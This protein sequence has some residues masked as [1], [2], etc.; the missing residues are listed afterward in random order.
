MS[1]V[2]GVGII[3]VNQQRQI[4]MGKRCGGYAPYWS[5]PGGRIEEGESFEQTAIRET[6]EETGL[7][8][9]AP[10]LIGVVNN[11]QTWLNEGTHTVSLIMVADYAGGE[12][13]R[14]EPDKC[15]GW[16][17]YSPD[18]LPAPCFE[19][20]QKGIRLWLDGEFY[21]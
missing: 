2:V 9:A 6:E 21:R 10:R 13:Q 3:I 7:I 5:I 15:E 12:P 20:S 8:I 17:W 4:L 18:A 11:L 14:R 16:G 19:G 1:I